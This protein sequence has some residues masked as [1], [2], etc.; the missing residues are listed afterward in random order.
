MMR[1]YARLHDLLGAQ[2]WWPA[3]TP[4]EVVVGAVLTQQ[5]RWENVEKAIG[6]LRQASLL[7]PDALV[8]AGSGQIEALVRCTG[9]YRQKAERLM[10]VSEY[11]AGID[12]DKDTDVLRQEL[13]ALKGVGEETAD[14]ILLYALGRPSFVIDAYT[15][16]ICECNGIVGTYDELQEAFEGSIPK[17][18]GLYKE[19]HALIV[20]YG[21]RYCNKKR[22]D[23]CILRSTRDGTGMGAAGG[24]AAP[25]G[26]GRRSRKANPGMVAI[27]AK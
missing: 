7:D 22:C 19:F 8:N 4:F 15:R 17:E 20:E 21:K 14:S 2:H 9:F 23:G 18:T 11:F 13:L 27:K 25:Q 12:L 1:M 6:N 26:K 16:R 24:C 10:R 3:D 5:T